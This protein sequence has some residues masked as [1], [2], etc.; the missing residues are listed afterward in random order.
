V[1][2]GTYRVRAVL[3]DSASGDYAAFITANA[4]FRILPRPL[5]ASEFSLTEN[6]FVYD[7][8]AHIPGVNATGGLNPGADFTVGIFNNVNAGT[9]SV[10]IVGTGNFTGTVTLDFTIQK[11]MLIKI[12]PTGLTAVFG[13]TLTDVTLP[14]GWTWISVTNSVGN[15]GIN[16]FGAVFVPPDALNF[17]TVSLQ[18]S[19][20]V[21][22]THG[23]AEVKISD[24]TRG[25][26]AAGSP[27]VEASTRIGDWKNIVF[28]YSADGIAWSTTAPDTIGT[29]FVRAV[30]TDSESGNYAD[31]TT[32]QKQFTVSE[33][34]VIPDPDDGNCWWLWFL[35]GVVIG[36]AVIMLLWF[37]LIKKK[38]D[39]EKERRQ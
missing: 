15:A 37:F 38:D 1:N 23:V 33:A 6:S 18:L 36:S 7:G 20:T 8:T 22:P 16:F 25:D 3:T 27:T 19:L 9:A 30:L 29:F 31:L 2:V 4:M 28:E 10:T 24:Y 5:D 21:L 26:A 35:I 17:Q 39:N 14:M 34:P 32:L 11:A 12:P 13:Q